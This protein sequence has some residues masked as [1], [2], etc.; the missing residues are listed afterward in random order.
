MYQ[1]FESEKAFIAKND[2]IVAT[3]LCG[4]ST[5]YANVNQCKHPKLNKWAMPVLPYVA[6][7]FNENELV[8]SLTS[9]W[10]IVIK[11]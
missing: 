10:Q 6:H 8:S 3:G 1:I 5:T 11:K 2:E 9:D 4:N 7:F